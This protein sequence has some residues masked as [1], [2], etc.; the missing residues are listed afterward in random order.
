MVI[1]DGNPASVGPAG[2]NRT[3]QSP[4]DRERDSWPE[5]LTSR[6]RSHSESVP[7]PSLGGHII[8]GALQAVIPPSQ[9][10]SNLTAAERG[11]RFDYVRTIAAGIRMMQR[12]VRALALARALITGKDSLLVDCDEM[13][14][15][16]VR[17]SARQRTC[18]WNQ[19]PCQTPKLSSGFTWCGGRPRRNGLICP[20]RRRKSS[21][22]DRV[23]HRGYL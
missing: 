22:H 19:T 12:L 4:E 21:S 23:R 20:H 16:R 7:T 15:S 6:I 17:D 2:V 18:M 11:I 14:W 13:V 8:S 10:L 1:P 3:P 9:R 5:G